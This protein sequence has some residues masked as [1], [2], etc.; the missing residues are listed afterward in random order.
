MHGPSVRPRAFKRRHDGVPILASSTPVEL[1]EVTF[2]PIPC[3]PEPTTAAEQVSKMGDKDY[4]AIYK[5]RLTRILADERKCS[6]LMW[7]RAQFLQRAEMVK[8]KAHGNKAAHTGT[9][10]S[11][12][13]AAG[14]HTE[15]AGLT[16]EPI[17][18]CARAD[19]SWTAGWH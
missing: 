5:A 11:V 4:D 15:A 13:P 19:A 18:D 9:S 6:L 10:P 1:T 16:S 12:S 3:D 14:T 17:P 2:E 8:M 7:Q